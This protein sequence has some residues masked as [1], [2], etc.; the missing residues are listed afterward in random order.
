MWRTS[1]APGDWL[2]SFSLSTKRL[3]AHFARRHIHWTEKWRRKSSLDWLAVYAISIEQMLI[4]IMLITIKVLWSGIR[5][6]KTSN[7][8]IADKDTHIQL[9]TRI[10]SVNQKWSIQL[11][12]VTVLSKDKETGILKNTPCP[13]LRLNNL[14]FAKVHVLTGYPSPHGVLENLYVS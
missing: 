4:A 3:W 9:T 5:G 13:F 10:S 11:I 7:T 2:L 6:L 12:H 1:T 8:N 14:T